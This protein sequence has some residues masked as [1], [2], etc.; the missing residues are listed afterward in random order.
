MNDANHNNST[1][2]FKPVTE[3]AVKSI[4]Q[5]QLTRYWER[6]RADYLLPMWP[7]VDATEIAASRDNLCVVDINRESPLLRYRIREHGDK[8]TEYY[9]G[10]F[11]GRFL[12][13]FVTPAAL[14][15][16]TVVYAQAVNCRRPVYTVSPITDSKGRAVTFERLLLPF[17]V[18][19]STV[20]VVLTSLEAISI[21]GAF[22]QFK[23]LEPSHRK[24]F[25]GFQCVIE[26]S[27]QS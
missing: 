22:E 2:A 11:S 15:A 3:S 16:L 19:G 6:L 8:L 9:G 10:V 21:D 1:S 24:A 17:T 7:Q 12:D 25:P 4:K 5:R 14:S 18:S 20:D 26:A 23:V 27:A 13:E